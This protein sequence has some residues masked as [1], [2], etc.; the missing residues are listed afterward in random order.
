MKQTSI[1]T[2]LFVSWFGLIGCNGSDSTSDSTLATDPDASEETTDFGTVEN[3]N[4]GDPS[5]PDELRGIDPFENAEPLTSSLL[6]TRTNSDTSVTVLND[7]L[8]EVT[9][10]FDHIEISENEVFAYESDSGTT[11]LTINSSTNDSNPTMM[12]VSGRL[13]IR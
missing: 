8:E 7:E 10:N 2:L 11:N 5:A 6:E 4:T 1:A 9:T 3:D 13:T 12:T